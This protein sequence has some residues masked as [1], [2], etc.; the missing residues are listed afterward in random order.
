MN[1]QYLLD[2]YKIEI[3]S[4][5]QKVTEEKANLAKPVL[6]LSVFDAIESGKISGNRILYEVIKPIYE[7]KLQEVQT[8]PTPLKY[9]F[10]HMKSDGFWKLE[11]KTN[12]SKIP[13]TPSDK[14]LR[15]NLAYA[16]FDNALW[17]LLQDKEARD[18]YRESIIN[19]YKVK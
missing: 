9:P 2:F 11:W 18:F 10:Y 14:F 1:N 16:M 13:A 15:D 5:K 6:L 19:Y 3:L 7:S 17:D 12:T 4:I 8:E